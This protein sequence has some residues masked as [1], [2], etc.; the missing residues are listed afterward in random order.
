M[1]LVEDYLRAVAILLP[2]DQRDDIVAE[3]RDLVLSRVEARESELARPLRDD[4]VEQV[5]REIG[6]PLVVA[7]RYRE[8]PQSI[9]GPALYPFWVFAVKAALAVQFSIIAIVFIVQA[10]G[11]G[12]V[13][14]A[15]GRAFAN[16]ITG[17]ATTIGFITAAAWIIERQAKKPDFVYKWRVKDLKML[18]IAA[19]D[20]DDWRGHLGMSGADMR[21]AD[22]AAAAAWSSGP[23]RADHPSR[24]LRRLRR[25]ERSQTSRG[26]GVIVGS[27]V[28]L[29]WWT[30]LLHF[31]FSA[32]PE[33]FRSIGLDPGALATFDWAALKADVQW[34]VTAYGLVSIACGFCVMARP[35]AYR[36]QGLFDLVQGVAMIAFVAW[37]AMI[38]PLTA[39]LGGDTVATLA[40]RVRDA[41]QGGP[42]F[43]LSAVVVLVLACMALNGLSRSIRGLWLIADPFPDGLYDGPSEAERR[44]MRSSAP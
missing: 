9:V 24:A 28:F 3:L 26:L 30:G 18:E 1:N 37:L 21:G 33:A 38:S 17:A 14:G 16:G 22:A 29:L 43:P 19:W 25:R 36:E 5:L 11:H 39:A 42:P 20:F 41:A 6:H 35:F 34:P 32:T 15:I 8:G 7:A 27:A 23:E 4:E 44:S 2:K 10:F 31:G 12:D 13:G 40:L